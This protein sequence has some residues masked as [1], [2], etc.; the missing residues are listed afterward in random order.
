[1]DWSEHCVNNKKNTKKVFNGLKR[2]QERGVTASHLPNEFVQMDN[3]T[4]T[5]MGNKKIAKS[6]KG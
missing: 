3:R 2:G 6:Y 1:M 5:D 4:G